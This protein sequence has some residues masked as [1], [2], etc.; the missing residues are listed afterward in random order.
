VGL[1]EEILAGIEE[2]PA[3]AIAVGRRYA[4][5]QAGAR[6]GVARSFLEEGEAPA[7]LGGLAGSKVCRLSLSRNRTEAAVGVASL[8]AQLPVPAR[9]DRG[10]VFDLIRE[11]APRFERIGVVG[12]FPF[13]KHLGGHVTVFEEREAQGCLPASEAPSYLPSCDLVVITG[14]AFVNGTLEGL[15]ALSGGYT[16]VIGPSTPL[17]PILFHHGADLLAGA[18]GG[19]AAVLEAVGGGGGTRSFIR[20][21]QTAIVRRD[22][23]G[24]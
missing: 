19:D 22:G 20:R 15:L 5:V 8:N 11:T 3:E 18:F 21:M 12:M 4:A 7:R 2:G 17:S 9:F 6:V 1:T 14:S 13:V 16:L 24:W 23:R 10:N